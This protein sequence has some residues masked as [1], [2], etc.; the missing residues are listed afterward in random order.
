LHKSDSESTGVL[1]RDA[2]LADAP[3]MGRL[4]VAAWRTAYSG[5]MGAEYLASLDPLEREQRWRERISEGAHVLVAC[6]SGLARGF[7]CYGAE[8]ADT[9]DPDVGELYAINLH[10]EVWR[11]G[12][13]A[14]LLA[15]VVARL[16]EA[17]F[18]EAVLWVVR[19]NTRARAF[20][21]CF[22][23]RADG[24]EKDDAGSTGPVVHEV[25]YRIAL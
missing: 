21:E 5:S 20:Y 19:E 6:E 1:I 7:A 23:W 14:Q 13:G 18:R 17:G 12:M 2:V 11:R 25:R 3:A 16:C 22:G 10:P 4:H 8:R 15:A 24:A 9:P